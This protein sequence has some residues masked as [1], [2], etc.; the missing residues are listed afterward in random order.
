MLFCLFDKFQ[1]TTLFVWK[2]LFFALPL[3]EAMK[4]DPP[5]V[6]IQQALL[7]PEFRARGASETI[8][9]LPTGD[10]AAEVEL[11]K[12]VAGNNSGFGYD[13]V[14]IA[15]FTYSAADVCN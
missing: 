4:I 1:F 6:G 14:P 3:V 10:R 5:R 9:F 12:V 15:N 13:F 11:V 2:C 8:K 7:T